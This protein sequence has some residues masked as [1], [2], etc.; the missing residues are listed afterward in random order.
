MKIIETMVD[1][2][3]TL[4]SLAVCALVCFAIYKFVTFNPDALSWTDKI[5]YA[6]DVS[7][8][9]ELFAQLLWSIE[10]LV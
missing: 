5:R 10:S 3:I 7:N 6:M 8:H 1:I 4:I 9:G 2:A